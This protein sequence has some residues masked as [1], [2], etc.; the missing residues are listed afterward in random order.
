MR[1]N[2]RVA[3]VLLA[4][5][6]GACEG[7][8]LEAANEPDSGTPRAPAH[9]RLDCDLPAAVEF[10]GG[11]TCHYSNAAQ[12]L[13]SSLALWDRQAGQMVENVQ[14]RLVNAPATYHNVVDPENCPAEA[15]L[16]ID[17]SDVERS[18]LLRKLAGMQTCGAEM[19]KFP[20]PEWGTVQNP[21][22]ER[23]QFVQCIRAWVSLLVEDYNRAL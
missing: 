10:C 19:P 20:Y 23:E 12:E 11:G 22:A 2:S 17:P 16:L 13:A 18:L 1:S 14:E 3:L 15:E 5:G 6:A 21:G 7:G 4:L 8:S 9:E